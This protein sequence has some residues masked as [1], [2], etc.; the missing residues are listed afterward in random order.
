MLLRYVLVLITAFASFASIA[1]EDFLK[2]DKQKF[3]YGIGLQIGQSLARQ[4]VEI[5]VEAFAQ[6]VFD[7]QNGL[8][9]RIAPE[10]L[11]KV[12]QKQQEQL[13]SKQKNAST[14]NLKAG[15]DF[16]AEN[17][18]KDGVKQTSSGLQYKILKEG[19]GTKPESS[20]AVVVHYTGKLLDGREFDSSH[21]RGEPA[22]LPLSGVIKGWQEALPMMREG[23][24]WQ[25][26]IPSDLA[27][28]ERGAG[29]VIGPNQ[30]LM[31]DIELIK[32]K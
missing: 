8:S 19:S 22:T 30:T 24:K 4:G 13:Q 7:A 21:R 3:S 28:G 23:A 14:D 17:M 6:A 1:E 9:P 26:Y 32:V 27:Y 25:L 10:E 15:K 31:F 16:L 12:M 20:G 11:N 29:G 18:K 5:D 2:S